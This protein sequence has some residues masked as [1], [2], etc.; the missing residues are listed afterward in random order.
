MQG[1][2]RWGGLKGGKVKRDEVHASCQRVEGGVGYLMKSTTG[3]MDRKAALAAL[4]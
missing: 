1:R 3:E 2:E 4:F